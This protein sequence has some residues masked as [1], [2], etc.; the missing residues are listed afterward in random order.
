M[1]TSILYH[2]FGIV[3][4]NYLKSSYENGEMIF[5]IEHN[6]ET[7]M[8]PDCGSTDV[9]R[10]GKYPRIIQTLPIGMKRVFI[11]LEVQRVECREC[12]CIKQMKIGFANER[13]SYSRQLERFVIEL[14]YKMSVQDISKYLGMGW[15]TVKE[16]HKRYLE[17]KYSK[18]VLKDLEMIAIDEIAVGQG[19]KYFTVVMDMATGAIVF[20]GDG[21]GSEALEPFWKR[22]NRSRAQIKAVAVDM[23]P[24]YRKAIEKHLPEATIIYDHFH[25]VKAFNEKLSDF[26]RSMYSQMKDEEQKRV[27]KSTRWLLLKNPENLDDTKDES[28]RLE[29]ALEINK[30]LAIVYYMKED[31]RQIWDQE[32]KIEAETKIMSWIEMAKCSGIRMLEKFAGTMKNHIKGILSWYDIKIS[33]GPL[34]ATNNKIKYILRQAFGFR[35]MEYFKL[36]IYAIHEAKYAL[37]G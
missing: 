10:K 31:L 29:K 3:G 27:L 32:N 22:L 14:S 20:T 23:S 28:L 36:K 21:K 9:I 37:I 5:S 30:P 18:P 25:L 33:T 6:S 11:Y 16:I 8:C 17:K 34:E 15:D 12:S 4:Y 13:N 2:C 26:R 1:S 19:H 7:L 24:A 35:D